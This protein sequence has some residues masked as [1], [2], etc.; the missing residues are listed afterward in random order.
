MENNLFNANISIFYLINLIAH[1]YLENNFFV[2]S[3]EVSNFFICM[4]N[5]IK[6]R[7]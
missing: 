7:Y 5:H 2:Y 3:K 6:M 4:L 1:N